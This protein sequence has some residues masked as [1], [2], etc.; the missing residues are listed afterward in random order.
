MDNFHNGLVIKSCIELFIYKV[1]EESGLGKGT[2]R[3]RVI[4]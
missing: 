2:G 4:L 1:T 3:L